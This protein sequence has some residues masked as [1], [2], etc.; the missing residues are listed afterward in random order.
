MEKARTVKILGRF[1]VAAPKVCHGQP[2]DTVGQPLSADT[3]VPNMP[4]W[5]AKMLST[6]PRE[7]VL[8]EL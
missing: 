8:L 2:T 7:K 3:G 1:I 4:S 6:L 5:K